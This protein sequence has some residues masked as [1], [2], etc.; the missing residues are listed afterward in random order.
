M[1]AEVGVHGFRYIFISSQLNRMI[2]SWARGL[3]GYDIAL[4]WRGSCVRIAASPLVVAE[5]RG[6]FSKVNISN[7]TT[8][9]NAAEIMLHRKV[10][11]C[12]LMTS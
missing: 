3:V 9:T 12:L 5:T 10:A 2:R 8:N 11:I 4:T 6:I 7:H 1:V